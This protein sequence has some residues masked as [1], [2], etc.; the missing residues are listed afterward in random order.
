MSKIYSLY[1][2]LMSAEASGNIRLANKLNKRINK[3]YRRK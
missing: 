1:D 3:L 2:A